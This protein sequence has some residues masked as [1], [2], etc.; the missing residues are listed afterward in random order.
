MDWQ[1]IIVAVVVIASAFL[2]FK[3]LYKTIK[4]PKSACDSCPMKDHCGMDC[5]DILKP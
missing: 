3:R 5:E 1:I 4:K 2:L